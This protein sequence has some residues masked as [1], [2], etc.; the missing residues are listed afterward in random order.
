M[1]SAACSATAYTTLCVCAD[2][3]SGTTLK[4]TTRSPLVPYTL[5]SESTT[6]P[7]S[8]GSIEHVDDVWCT[9]VRYLFSHSEMS[10]SERTSGPGLTSRPRRDAKGSVCASA[11][12]NLTCSMNVR[13]SVSRRLRSALSPP[14]SRSQAERASPGEKR[15]TDVFLEVVWVDLGGCERVQGGGV[16]RAARERPVERRAQRY[17]LRSQPRRVCIT[18]HRSYVRC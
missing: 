11:R 1:I 10:A 7:L 3:I 15:R 16:D 13:R 2:G 14:R 8:R 6:P 4:S 12:A 18:K 5:N 17:V 9:V